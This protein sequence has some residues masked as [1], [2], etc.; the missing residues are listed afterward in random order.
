ML[1]TDQSM[2]SIKRV[3]TL[4]GYCR[5]QVR[6]L[7]NRLLSPVVYAQTGLQSIETFN[8]DD[9]FIV[10]YPKS[11]NTWF[12]NLVSGLNYGVN[13]QFASDSLVQELV[14]DVHFK[15]YY[16]RYGNPMFFKSHHLPTSK[17]RKV[18]YLIRDGRD[19]V[20]SY[21]HF[22]VA[23]RGSTVSYQD[24]LDDSDSI[25]RWGAWHE[26]VDK[27][28]QN[29]YGAELLIIKYED[30]QTDPV[31]ELE[32]FCDFANITREAKLLETVIEN[33]SFDNMRKREVQFG[34]NNPR[35]PRDKAFMRRGRVGSYADEMPADILE[36]FLEKAEQTLKIHG[37]I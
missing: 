30:L 17:Y 33:C 25:L 13:L 35:W 11:G 28:C 21:Y 2:D 32:K 29:P 34:L 36:K 19:V 37:Y 31:S 4:L 5:R 24:L 27:W 1:T 16:Q 3:R 6:S 9:I 15:K 10:G 14:P 26:H 22:L 8:N 12:Q 18:V 7:T 20:V 23:L